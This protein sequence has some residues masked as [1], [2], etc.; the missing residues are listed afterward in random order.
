MTVDR[1][2]RM[3]NSTEERG[4]PHVL[5]EAGLA[6]PENHETVGSTF[7]LGT[8]DVASCCEEA[9]RKM[10]V[11]YSREMGVEPQ[12]GKILVVF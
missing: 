5:V 10:T 9:R 6:V 3:M 7:W 12:H 8:V 4:T 1:E 2:F 11:F